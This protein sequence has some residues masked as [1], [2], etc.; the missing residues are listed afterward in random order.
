MVVKPP[1]FIQVFLQ[2]TSKEPKLKEHR[3]WSSDDVF[4]DNLFSYTFESKPLTSNLTITKKRKERELDEDGKE[5]KK[6]SLNMGCAWLE[7]LDGGS[8]T[9]IM[10]CHQNTKVF[11]SSFPSL[12]LI[13]YTHLL[14][15]CFN[16][17]W[18]KNITPSLSRSR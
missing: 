12:I 8:L 17:E 5:G 10:F 14:V 15:P 7:F 2:Y 18:T 1:V 3:C 11:F 16:N 13:V 4:V 6:S 9:S